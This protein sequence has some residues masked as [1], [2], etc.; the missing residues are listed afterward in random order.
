M[1]DRAAPGRPDL[2]RILGENARRVDRLARLPRGLAPGQL[3]GG[4]LDVDHA[5]L[6]VDHDDIAVAQEA[7]RPG[8]R[9]LGPDMPDAK[10]ARRAGEAAVGDECVVL[11]LALA[12]ERGR[13]REHLAHARSALGPLIAN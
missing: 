1:R 9:R 11:A 10:P 2:T 12:V 3:I 13:R 8:V 5:L 4:K 7:D 6:R